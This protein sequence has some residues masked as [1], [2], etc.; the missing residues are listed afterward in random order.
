MLADPIQK[1]F[2]TRM[3]EPNWQHLA[4]TK[5]LISLH[6]SPHITQSGNKIHLG[7]DET[8][9]DN[10]SPHYNPNVMYVLHKTIKRSILYNES[11]LISSWLF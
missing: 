11:T 10:Y 6:T 3:Q 4:I 5:R 1:C 2:L 9:N 8:E 7:R